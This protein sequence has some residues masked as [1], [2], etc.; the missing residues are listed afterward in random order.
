MLH[1]AQGL[2]WSSRGP[3]A[4][5]AAPAGGG[6]CWPGAFGGVQPP[7]PLTRPRPRRA[8]AALARWFSKQ[9][10]EIHVHAAS[11]AEAALASQAA[12]ELAAVALGS[13]PC[14]AGQGGACAERWRCGPEAEARRGQGVHCGGGEAW[15]ALAATLPG[16]R[17]SFASGARLRRYADEQAAIVGYAQAR[18]AGAGSRVRPP[19]AAR[20]LID[21]SLGVL[22]GAEAT[23]AEEFQ[24]EF[25]VAELTDDYQPLQVDV[26]VVHPGLVSDGAGIAVPIAPTSKVR[27]VLTLALPADVCP[28]LSPHFAVLGD[29]SML[30]PAEDGQMATVA[31]LRVNA[32]GGGWMGPDLDAVLG[33]ALGSGPWRGLLCVRWPPPEPEPGVGDQV[34]GPDGQPLPGATAPPGAG[35]AAAAARWEPWSPPAGPEHGISD[36]QARRGAQRQRQP[37]GSGRAT[38]ATQAA[39]LERLESSNQDVLRR[40][41][42][43]EA[44]GG[45]CSAA[46][47]PGDADPPRAELG[48]GGPPL[49]A[50]PARRRDAARRS[51]RPSQVLGAPPAEGGDWAAVAWALSAAGTPPLAR[52]G[53]PAGVAA[54]SRAGADM[55]TIRSARADFARHRGVQ[56]A[57]VAEGEVRR[58][59]V[60][61]ATWCQATAAAPAAAPPPRAAAPQPAGATP[62]GLA[63]RWAAVAELQRIPAGGAPHAL[64]GILRPGLDD[65][66]G[67][68]GEMPGARGAAGMEMLRRDLQMRPAA[69]S[70]M[71]RGNT[72][73]ALA[74][75]NDDPDPRVCSIE[76]FVV[77]AGSINRGNRTAAHLGFG[78]ARVA[79]LMA[80]GQREMAEAVV[81]L[82]LTALE[83]AQRNNGRWQLSW[84][85]THLP[86]QPWLQMASGH[87]GSVD[88]LRAFGHLAGPTWAAAAMA[89]TKGAASLADARRK[90]NDDRGSGGRVAGAAGL[91]EGLAAGVPRAQIGIVRR[92]LQIAELQ[93]NLM[94]VACSFLALGSTRW[95]P[96]S[97][98]T[99]MGLTDLQRDRLPHLLALAKQWSR[100]PYRMSS[101]G[102]IKI[103]GLL[104]FAMQLR[105]AAPGQP[106]RALPPLAVSPF[107]ASRAS[108]CKQEAHFDPVHR[109]PVFEAAAYVDP[110]PIERDQPIEHGLKTMRQRLVSGHALCDFELQGDF[111]P[112]LFAEFSP[113]V[114]QAGGSLADAVRARRRRLFPRGP[115]AE[116]L[117]MDDR[118]GIG[119]RARGSRRLPPA[120]VS[121]LAGAREQCAKVGLKALGDK[122][123]AGDAGGF[124]LG[125]EVLS[126]GHIGAERPRRAGL[127]LLSSGI[128]AHGIAD[129]ALLRRSVASLVHV[130]GFRRPAMC[131]VDEGLMLLSMLAPALVTKLKAKVAPRVV[132]SDASHLN[133]SAVVADVAQH[134][135][136][137]I[138]RHRDQR[139]WYIPLNCKEVAY[140]S[141]DKRPEDRAWLQDIDEELRPCTKVPRWHLLE[142]HAAAGLRVGPRIDP[143]M[144]PMW[145]LRSTRIVE[146]VLFL[147]MN[148]WVAYVHCAPP[149]TTFSVAR[150]PRLRSRTQPLGLAA[151]NEAAQLGNVLLF[152]VLLILWAARTCGARGS[153]E[154]LAGACTWHVPAMKMLFGKADCGTLDFAA[155]SFGVPF[156]M[157]TRQGL[158]HA[159]FLLPLARPCVHGR[160]ARGRPL[161]GAARTSPAAAYSNQ[162]CA[163]WAELSRAHL[164]KAGGPSEP[165]PARADA[166]GR[167]EQPFVDDLIRCCRWR[168]F[169]CD[170]CP[171]AVHIN[172]LEIRARMR[173]RSRAARQELGARQSF[174]LDSTVALGARAKGR[175]AWRALNDDLELGLPDVLGFD[176]Y[177]GYDFAPTRLIPSEWCRL[178]VKLVQLWQLKEFDSALGYLGAGPLRAACSWTAAAA[179]MMMF[180]LMIITGVNGA[181]VAGEAPAA[182]PAVDLRPWPQTTAKT[183][184]MRQLLFLKFESWLLKL[185]GR[186][187]LGA[188]VAQVPRVVANVVAAYGQVLYSRGRSLNHSTETI[189]AVVGVEWSLRR[190]MGAAWEVAQAWQ[191]AV[192][193]RHPC[194]A[195][196]PVL[197]ALVAL[198]L[199]WGWADVAVLILL[200]FTCVLRPGEA[201]GLC[202]S[203]S[204]LPSQLMSDDE[205]CYVRVR[206][207]K[208]RWAVARMEHARCDEVIL[209]RLLERLAEGQQR[210]QRIF[211]GSYPHFRRCN[212]ALVQFFGVAAAETRG[213]V[214]RRRRHFIFPEVRGLASHAVAR[215]VEAA[216]A[217][218]DLHPGVA[219]VAFVP[220]LAQASRQ[221]VA[222]FA[223]ALPGLLA[224][225]IDGLE[226]GKI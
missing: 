141:V 19:A 38:V 131:L 57:E 25:R 96:A 40:V 160:R 212:D 157:P 34:V 134:I 64:A 174:L 217:H 22:G 179:L 24:W 165:A 11:G 114:L 119:Q 65:G 31:F 7:R 180:A 81:L 103:Q 6:G 72:E 187:S 43:P 178:I 221:L 52:F 168:A 27:G 194:P 145:D 123:V 220:N 188:L 32:E 47:P 44:A 209:V 93:V 140:I 56:L 191:F 124:A 90:F 183:A 51:P 87:S 132:C 29:P 177:P 173:A 105:G 153:F 167:L 118:V 146:W 36:A 128:A 113:A 45:R 73:L 120:L 222:S 79:D 198:A 37:A 148:E 172:R 107:A 53:Q 66:P 197:R 91:L 39:M 129:G 203:D 144:H 192:P 190:H 83:Q 219:A 223:A 9:Y 94:V 213:L 63:A 137:E 62:A 138:W 50:A 115:R 186:C 171:P 196:V 58:S 127:A 59:P 109:L 149:C 23:S 1:A 155:C 161:L 111:V 60:G 92:L 162:L 78:L 164:V 205:V 215:A 28:W 136:R 55:G 169:C 100:A 185:D 121:L 117:Q 158:V 133:V 126:S 101:R 225:A 30:L 206:Q 184:Q 70:N 108:L 193:T 14:V 166:A 35:A 208:A 142:A 68:A 88:S 195:P 122:R 112:V 46:A 69:W 10:V 84:L 49:A 20:A 226:R 189:N 135:V 4:V 218:G 163:V 3:R 170:P 211:R 17:Y 110:S 95:C 207:P 201:R 21:M 82:L 48:A 85:L 33:G 200:A 67:V 181:P 54:A 15:K 156:Q 98:K 41:F 106:G 75:A 150:Q 139:G 18:G 80:R 42:A 5:A 204:L 175:S 89:Y 99:G 2:P 116:L 97:C 12:A 214:P 152:R 130:M 104:E 8:L 13:T 125:A 61:I 16:G 71:I 216:R 151:A 176:V 86:E 26:T 74:G 224:R 199:S 210:G 76:E 143:K 77:R 159:D 202:F 147:I 102:K 154:H 182:R